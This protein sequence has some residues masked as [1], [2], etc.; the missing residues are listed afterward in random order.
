MSVDN[1]KPSQSLMDRDPS[2]LTVSPFTSYDLL[3]EMKA[4]DR[5]FQHMVQCTGAK[6]LLTI[7]I[8]R[9]PTSF[10]MIL[11]MNINGAA[12]AFKVEE[13]D[14]DV[15]KMYLNEVAEAND[16]EIGRNAMSSMQGFAGYRFCGIEPG[17]NG[18]GETTESTSTSQTVDLGYRK[19][20]KTKGTDP[21]QSALKY[22]EWN[23]L[24]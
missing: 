9:T 23:K 14:L 20:P 17:E 10:G 18:I 15:L 3:A 6:R 19:F 16:G 11:P 24:Q 4:P 7:Y 21:M 2:P 8:K 13:Q 22:I 5:T 12:V 1:L